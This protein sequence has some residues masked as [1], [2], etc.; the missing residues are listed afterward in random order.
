[1][2]DEA[3]GRLADHQK[4]RNSQASGIGR[5]RVAAADL[6]RGLQLCEFRET[7]VGEGRT[8]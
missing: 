2:A 1:M 5:R 7:A 6:D 3:S 8:F 4:H